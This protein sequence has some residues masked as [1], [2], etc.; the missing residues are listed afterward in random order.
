M[1]KFSLIIL[2]CVMLLSSCDAAVTIQP[3]SMP[4]ETVLPASTVTP[5]PT[6]TPQPTSLPIQSPTSQNLSQLQPLSLLEFDARY[7]TGDIALSQDE[8]FLAVVARSKLEDDKS[9]W[10]WNV[11]DLNQSLAGFRIS[12]DDLWSVAFSP[13]G[14]QLAVGGKAKII[15]IDWRTGFVTATIELPYSEAIQVAYGQNNTL[16]WSSFSN[17]VTVRN[18][19]HNEAKYYVDGITGLNPT[20]FAL[21]PDEKVLVTGAY[22]GIQLWDFETGESLGF[23]EGPDGG[24]GIA[25]I[26]A[27]SNK[28]NFLASTGCGE[29]G[30]ESCSSGNI[31]IWKPDSNTPLI[32]PNVHPRWISALAFSP[33]EEILASADGTDVIKLIRLADGKIIT[34]PT[35]KK[36]GQMPPKDTLHTNDIIFFPDGKILAVS[37]ND[38]I[39]FLDIAK[40]SWVPNLRFFLSVGY[41]YMI[42]REGDNLNL[43]MGPSLREQ[44]ISIL[45]AGQWF[46]VIG[47][48][49]LAEGSIWWKIKLVDSTEGWVVEMPDWYAFPP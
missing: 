3:T 21:S 11:S 10:V 18:L 40:M 33:N 20:S 16:V 26:S 15:V 45:R 23:R 28:G 17:M 22:D 4:V 24:I 2:V 43:R 34:A 6:I 35:L 29:F 19:S 36:P 32:I 48:P 7:S 13:D 27:F 41:K 25:P 5:E 9:V 42:T 8:K 39:Q 30:F 44:V 1:K 31:L 46:T 47:G 12:L 49:K 14:S 38:G 37:T